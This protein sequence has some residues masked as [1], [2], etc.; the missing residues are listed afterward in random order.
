MDLKISTYLDKM[1][2]CW[3][4]KNIGGTLGA[5]FEGRR[6]T[7]DLEYYTHDLSLGVL[8]NDDLDLQLVFLIA[9]EAYGK[10][11]NSEVLANYWVSHIF[12][13]FSEY[14]MG[15]RN[16]RAG[17]LPSASGKHHNT[18]GESNGA[19]IRS[20]IWACLCPGHPELA[21]QYAYEDASVDH[22]GEG[23]YAEV[24]CA[25]LES[26]AFV[27]SDMETLIDVALS[28]IPADCDVARAVKFVRK[29]AADPSLDWKAARKKL[30]IEFPSSFGMRPLPGEKMD[31]EIPAGRHG[32]DAP[33]NIGLLLLGHY[34]SGGDFSRAVCIAAGCCEDSDCTAG[35]LGAIYGIIGGTAAIDEKWLAPIG[36]EIKVKCVDTTKLHVATTV[37]ELSERIKLLMP[38]FLHARYWEGKMQKNISIDENGELTVHTKD[39]TA[40]S[41]PAKELGFRRVEFFR[42]T[43]YADRMC[44]K[45]ESPFFEVRAITDTLDI[46][47]GKE[48]T[49][50]LDILGKYGYFQRSDWNT[51]ILHLPEEWETPDGREVMFQMDLPWH[52]KFYT[53]SFVPRE[54]KKASY[55]VMLEVR[56][57]TFPSRIYIPLVLTRM[58]KNR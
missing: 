31:P 51:V 2:A 55:E 28:Y 47:E 7:V 41:C 26:A 44:I 34:Y 38:S 43:L 30:L 16:L 40:L 56:L 27:E 46:E 36:D 45:K 57:A 4:G 50:D 14:G 48:F 21:T 25:A 53:L 39:G 11:V 52:K 42:D 32:Y 22:C 37:S 1:R 18:F 3:L 10:N 24:F 35:T 6:G 15:K 5:P 23:I 17:I 9:C 49:V 58:L 20:E 12:A 19:W 29:C 8:P 33:N 54:L 13:D